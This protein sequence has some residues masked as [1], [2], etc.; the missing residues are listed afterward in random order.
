VLPPVPP[1]PPSDSNRLSHWTFEYLVRRFV[2]PH[3]AEL[4]RTFYETRPVWLR[5]FASVAVLVAAATKEP[6]AMPMERR[7]TFRELLKLAPACMPRP[8]PPAYGDSDD[9]PVGYVA[10]AYATTDGSDVYRRVVVTVAFVL[11]APLPAAR[12]QPT[13]SYAF[14][15]DCGAL[16]VV[17]ARTGAEMTAVL[18]ALRGRVWLPPPSGDTVREWRFDL[19]VPRA[20]LLIGRS[21][22]CVSTRR[23]AEMCA[24][25]ERWP[26]DVLRRLACGHHLVAIR[27]W[28][29]NATSDDTCRARW[30]PDAATHT[31]ARDP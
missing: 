13:A 28:L 8:M 11:P 4:R 20:P 1:P 23:V 18:R 16:G 12:D 21:V 9:A 3:L 30:F 24:I 14:A 19:S 26:T 5:V 2:A 25:R 29:A 6:H 15:L 10:L 31:A 7:C 17:P 22:P 27:A